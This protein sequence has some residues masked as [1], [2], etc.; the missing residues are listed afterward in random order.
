MMCPYSTNA[1]PDMLVTAFVECEHIIFHSPNNA[2]LFS[3]TTPCWAT[4]R[5]YRQSPAP[6]RE[7]KL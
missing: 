7:I 6:F 4:R 3:A 5:A 2:T 1:M